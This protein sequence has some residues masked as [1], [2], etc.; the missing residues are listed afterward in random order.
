[1]L[2]FIIY[3]N[4]IE[5]EKMINDKK[6]KDYLSTVKKISAPGLFPIGTIIVKE[7]ERDNVLRVIKSEKI[8]VLDIN[9]EDNN[10]HPDIIL[11]KLVNR[12][13][14]KKGI[15]FNIK[16]NLPGKIINQLNNLSHNQVNIHLPGKKN[17]VVLNPVPRG[18]FIILLLNNKQYYKMML[19]NI[20]TSFCNLL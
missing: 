5:T 4:K 2:I 18:G 6:L 20:V 16:T 10:F 3:C 12:L 15:I 9:N 14:E 11:D 1:M 13:K 7:N 19:G 8:F 17:S